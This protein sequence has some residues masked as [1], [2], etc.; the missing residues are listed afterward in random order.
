[1]TI[2]KFVILWLSFGFIIWFLK[3]FVYF[4]HVYDFAYWVA[5]L[6]EHLNKDKRVARIINE[7]KDSFIITDMI[8]SVLFG[9]ISL[10]D[11]Y[12][13]SRCINLI[14]DKSND[15]SEPPQSNE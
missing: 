11:I 4:R 13:L 12:K 5:Y 14:S 3:C 1:V 10:I 2:E 6:Y 9:P 8:V 15:P 7:N